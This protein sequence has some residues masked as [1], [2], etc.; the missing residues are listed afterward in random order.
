MEVLGLEK[1]STQEN[2]FELG[3]HSLLATRVIS[4]VRALGQVELPL[5][6]LFESPTVAGLAR[7]VE[8]AQ[9][10]Q[11]GQAV[12]ARIE[13]VERRESGL[14][15]SFAQQRL[16]FLDQLESDSA[17]Y[18]IPAALR[19]RGEL[20]KE[21]L[22]RTLTEIVRRHEVL[23]TSFTT[24]DGEPVQLIAPPEVLALSMEDLSQLAEEDREAETQRLTE[25]E[26]QQP[27]D[28]QH[29][30]MLRAR[31]L[32]L[33][34]QD[35]VLLLTM[36]HIVSDGW[37]TG[38]LLREAQLLYGAF[39]QGSPSPIP[40]LPIQ[41]GDFSVWQR[42]W[43][44]GT[45]LEE[46]LN[47]W[48]EQLQDAPAVLNL[49][50]DFARPAVQ[51]FR[52]S[53]ETRLLP[54]ELTGA[55][56]GL[57]QKA[58]TTL[59]MTLLAGFQTLLSRY[60]GQQDIVVGT[61][62][63]NRTRVELEDLIGFFVNTLVMRANLSDDPT[64][65]ELLNQ[66]R[67]TCLEAYLH[68]D[69]PF[70]KLVEE[71][72]PERSL[73]HSPVFQAMFVMQNQD[74][75]EAGVAEAVA[76]SG[77]QLQAVQSE[78]RTAKFDLTLVIEEKA[79]GLGASLEYNT[80]LFKAETMARM[81][82]QFERLLQSIVNEPETV[83]SRLKLLT[84]F[85]EQ[86]LRIDWNDTARDYQIA[87][88]MHRLF[89]AQVERTPSATAL[90]FEDK[91]FSYRELNERANKLAHHL[92]ELGVSTEDRVGN[93]MERSPAMIV[94]L[95]SVLKA[96]GCYVPLDPQYPQERLEF[97]KA[98]AGLRVLLTTRAMAE[99]RGLE[100]SQLVYVDEVESENS[101]NLS[102][103]VSEQ[104]L[105]YLIYTSGSTG[106]PKGVA[107]THGSATTFIHWASEV[108]DDRALN[109]VLFSTSI[110]FDLSIFELFV[111]LS[112]GGK[113][114]LA[115]NALQL[116]ELAAAKQVTLINTVPSAMAEL[117]RLGAVPESVK[118]VNLAGEALSKE[119][120]AEIYGTTQVETVYNL[121]GP[122]ED[123]TYSTF[124]PTTPDELVTIG[125]PIANTRAYVLDQHGQCVP[126]GVVGELYLGGAGLA[127]G[128]WAR[129]ELT[130][131]KFIP[132]SFS[133]TGGG[134]LYR[135]GDLAR[136]LE[137]GELEF[138]GRADN[139][140]K[141]R[142][143]RIE[144]GEIESELRQHVQEAVVVARAEAGEATRLVGYVVSA[145]AISSAELRDRL[146][147]RL[148]EY[149]VP[150]AF[151]QLPELPLTP[152]GKVDRKALPEPERVANEST[153]F[154]AARTPLEE[155]IAGIWMEVLGLEKVSTQEN[156]FELG[157]H[158]LL[159]TRVISRVRALGQVELPLRTLFES[160]TVAGLARRVEEAQ[161]SQ[162]G[163]AVVAR[164]APVE[165]R[166]SG[167]P[168]SFAQQRLWFLNQLEAG[169]AAY[170]IPAALRLRG[171]LDRDA[172]A[173]TL[174]EIVRRHEVLRT[175]FTTRGG[176][177]V[178]LVA[179]PP[180]IN[181]PVED[182]SQLAESDREVEAQRLAEAE[183]R[184]PFDLKYDPMLRAR[185]LRLAE[186]EHMLLLTM[187]HI[188]SDGWSM[189]VLLSEAQQ[190][191]HAYREGQDSPLPELE[192]QYG[193]FSVW[194]RGLPDGR[195]VGGTVAVLARAVARLAAR[196][197]PADR[198]CTSGGSIHAWQRGN[199]NA[200]AGVDAGIERVEPRAW[201][202]PVHDA[203]RQFPDPLVTVLRTARH[204][205]WVARREPY[206]SRG[207]KFDRVLR[208]HA[209][210]ACEA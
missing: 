161:R 68:Q 6:T 203:A 141:V 176:E 197:Q 94:S 139:Q 5:R 65:I 71:L 148:P 174:T 210:A 54:A 42:E 185:L 160:P 93:L 188:V 37:S 130:A 99:E 192:M 1:V 51:S 146:R 191:Y 178:Q 18:N 57:S 56:R 21:A 177:P 52:G 140:V 135:T 30:P 186:Q 13:P 60:T 158:S 124:T 207:R 110:C 132:D 205:G 87:G 194:Q 81:L 38:V 44:T 111:T 61:P 28:L 80:D 126:V 45:V 115:Q 23:R 50:T 97:M 151:V 58:S 143:Y 201:S 12:V 159:A 40:E 190:L 49:P 145:T 39:S 142:G 121:Y 150:S 26:A 22:A 103:E 2:F 34:E 182:L 10:S 69:L 47:Y 175:N 75:D 181:L 74:A 67:E 62:V 36:H 127:R 41:Y 152:N 195:W 76:A 128:Y 172:L 91:R 120:V 8:E 20:D 183:A 17:A 4:R 48:R 209:R 31:L 70:E 187:H 19:L 173:R 46:Q 119:L 184:T 198:P 196:S 165:R 55:L 169:S 59:Y 102:V 33:A 109:G 134:R 35:H 208:E 16:W 15:L 78:Q 77:L 204:R 144:L 63:A 122:S 11:R 118:V 89:E 199:A 14:P 202:D 131:T 88:G 155:L 64:F 3:G 206:T 106:V 100:Q 85:E 156:F 107:I 108:F 96:G 189:S 9:R 163:Q 7:R 157:G 114:I 164:I 116:P 32:R 179:A 123:T 180:V 72:A 147:Q 168:L 105:A 170:N 113:V 53:V 84:A 104:Q 25:Q 136:Y 166:E 129:P 193:D 90:I 83:V 73:S 24:H 101:E 171:E 92:R 125:R 29:G 27:F 162:R 79:T 98:D 82:G 137:N 153:R 149:M 154:V 66:T 133:E 112:N 200:L 138:L 95:L 86:K 117:V 43:L 167:L